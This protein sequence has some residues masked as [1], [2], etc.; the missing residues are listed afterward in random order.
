ME[1]INQKLILNKKVLLRYDIDV[2]LGLG[3]GGLGL[4]VKEDFKLKAGIETLKLC[5]QN[6]LKVIVIGH[7]GRPFATAED[8]ILG[9]NNSRFWNLLAP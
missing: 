9:T 2:A 3:V 4:K 8:E 1:T 6:A 7:L 5:L